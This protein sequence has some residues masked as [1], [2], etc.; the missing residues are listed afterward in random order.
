MQMGMN[1]R[2]KRGTP[3]KCPAGGDATLSSNLG[4]SGSWQ[5]PL[6]TKFKKPYP[7]NNMLK[8]TQK[9][10][11]A[12]DVVGVQAPALLLTSWAIWVVYPL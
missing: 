4:P 11:S 6:V 9:W 5:G 3:E 12:R 10:L 7:I 8:A 2:A 1:V